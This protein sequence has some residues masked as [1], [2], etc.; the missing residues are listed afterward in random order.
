[1]QMVAEK[2]P[3]RPFI[4][5]GSAVVGRSMSVRSQN[6]VITH[7]IG[8]VRNAKTTADVSQLLMRAGGD[9]R[10]VREVR[11]VTDLP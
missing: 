11:V 8:A 1:M 7:I 9:T 4:V 3:D 10:V 6:R 5:V 2:Y